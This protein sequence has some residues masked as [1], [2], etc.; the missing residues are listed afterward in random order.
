MNALELHIHRLQRVTPLSEVADLFRRHRFTS[1]PVTGPEGRYLGVIFQ[2]HLI[3]R[4][5]EDA[6]RLHHGYLAAFRRLLDG[7]RVQPVRAL[8]IMSV[9]GARAVPTTPVAVLL[10]MMAA[11]ARSSLQGNG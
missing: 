7:D 6:L 11:L 5:R 8:G 3:T 2:M 9:A 4:A 10:P 1:L